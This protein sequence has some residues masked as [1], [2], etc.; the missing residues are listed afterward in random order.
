MLNTKVQDVINKQINAELSASYSYLAMSAW[1]DSASFMGAATWF[2]MQS[3]EEYAHAMRL[4][5][6]VL[7]RGGQ[8]TLTELETPRGSYKTLPEV[9][10]TA[11]KQEQTVTAQINNL[12]DVAFQ[13]KAFDAVVQAEWFVN[14]Q[15]EEEKT[16]REIVA[17]LNMVK[18]DPPSLLDF[19]REL[20]SR[21]PEAA[22]GGEAGE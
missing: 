14:E 6:F 10:E 8:I 16:M 4:F 7:A 19:D 11:Y 9:F 2:R 12:Y 21:Q 18:D 20:G 22:G 1:C 15:V 13:A 17:Q 5:D 3:Q